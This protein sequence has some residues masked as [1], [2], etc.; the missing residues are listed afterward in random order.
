M[1]NIKPP[2]SR[3]FGTRRK[4]R[5]NKLNLEKNFWCWEGKTLMI[6]F[7]HMIDFYFSRMISSSA[8]S[9]DKYP[10]SNVAQLCPLIQ[11]HTFRPARRK[12]SISILQVSWR[13]NWII[14]RCASLRFWQFSTAKR[15]IWLEWNLSHSVIA[16]ELE[17]GK[18]IR[19]SIFHNK[20]FPRRGELSITVSMI[21]FPMLLSSRA[22]LF[23]DEKS[24]EI[25][26]NKI[27]FIARKMWKSPRWI[28]RLI[29]GAFQG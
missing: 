4:Q 28:I 26:F 14:F 16:V 6:N 1:P 15:K 23:L 13:E 7:H 3:V 20:P 8:D 10:S 17:K 29:E 2:S 12:K 19:F 18:N 9:I 5:N 27:L 22:R 21:N 11:S 25:T 24:T